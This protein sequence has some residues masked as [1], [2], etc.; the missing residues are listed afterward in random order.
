M[1]LKIYFIILA[2]THASLQNWA[3]MDIIREAADPKCSDHIVNS[4]S[5]IDDILANAPSFFKRQLKNLFGLGDLEHDE[6][7]A[8]ILEVSC[9]SSYTIRTTST[10]YLAGSARRMASQM[11][12]SQG[13]QYCF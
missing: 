3:Y 5:T 8:S 7:F 4:I 1:A 11:L 6:D 12:G 13:W 10:K 9:Y 2:V